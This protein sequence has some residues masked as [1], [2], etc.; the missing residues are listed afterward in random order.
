MAMLGEPSAE[1]I[2]SG[3]ESNDA[4]VGKKR[5]WL[6]QENHK[7]NGFIRPNNEAVTFKYDQISS[8]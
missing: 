3:F 6:H 2:D 1:K 4:D 5:C 7:K 8:E